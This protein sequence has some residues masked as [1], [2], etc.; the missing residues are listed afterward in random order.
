MRAGDAVFYLN[1]LLHGSGPNRATEARP[2]V[3]GTLMSRD[4]PMTVY[5]RNREQPRIVERY[6]VPDDY[7]NRM[8][9]FDRDHKLRPSVGRRL[10]DVEDT[11]N[12]SR[13]EIITAF[14]T[15]SQNS[16]DARE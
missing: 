5:F 9:N 4:T 15:L 6:E 3:L 16:P 2:L 14:R 10:E 11:Y 1:S 8:E 7:F 12:L 13:D